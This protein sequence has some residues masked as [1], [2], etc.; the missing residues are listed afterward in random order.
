M[1]TGTDAHAL[2]GSMGITGYKSALVAGYPAR[3]C[4]QGARFQRGSGR[5]CI[6]LYGVIGYYE[7]TG[8]I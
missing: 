8:T 3:T 7:V 6:Y 4:R 2:P 1:F 5:I